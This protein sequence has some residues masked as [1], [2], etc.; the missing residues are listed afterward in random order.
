MGEQQMIAWWQLN[1]DD[2]ALSLQIELGSNRAVTLTIS[3]NGDG[4]NATTIWTDSKEHAFG[5]E[6]VA[7][8]KQWIGERPMIRRPVQQ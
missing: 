2:E 5:N 7:S 8:F 4:L 3:K 6:T 1:E